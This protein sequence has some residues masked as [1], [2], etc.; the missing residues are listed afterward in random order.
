MEETY[1]L[2]DPAD[3]PLD[4]VLSRQLVD[5]PFLFEDFGREFVRFVIRHMI[6]NS[7]TSARN[8]LRSITLVHGPQ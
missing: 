7:N 4:L 6:Q 5:V 2:D 3:S 8:A 1:D